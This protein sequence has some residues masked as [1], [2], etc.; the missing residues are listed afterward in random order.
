MPRGAQNVKKIHA[1][2]DCMRR[3]MVPEIRWKARKPMKRVRQEC[4]LQPAQSALGE[5]AIDW[6][7]VLLERDLADLG[8]VN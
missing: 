1:F 7:V 8:G 4:W 6:S 5:D 2:L 3:P